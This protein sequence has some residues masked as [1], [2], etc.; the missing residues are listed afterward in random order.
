[1][2]NF[3]NN[4]LNRDED[5]ELDLEF[6]LADPESGASSCLPTVRIIRCLRSGEVPLR[7]KPL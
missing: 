2:P 4:L 1:M 3:L 7:E 6:D 5:E